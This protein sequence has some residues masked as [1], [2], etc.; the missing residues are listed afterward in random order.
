MVRLVMTQV[1]LQS[2]NAT[3]WERRIFRPVS[4]GSDVRFHR[5]VSIAEQQLF[6]RYAEVKVVR[7]GPKH[8]QTEI[9]HGL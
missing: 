3:V 5:Q 6:R 4:E 7:D 9:L 1:Q 2:Q 8:P